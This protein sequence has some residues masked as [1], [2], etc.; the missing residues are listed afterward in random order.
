LTEGDT[1]EYSYD[2]LRDACIFLHSED[3]QIILGIPSRKEYEAWCVNLL[4]SFHEHYP[5]KT[6][7]LSFPNA[8]ETI[9]ETLADEF[10]ENEDS[11]L[12]IRIWVKLACLVPSVI[13]ARNAESV[14]DIITIIQEAVS[15]LSGGVMPWE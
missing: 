15:E 9:A 1:F 12:V 13:L 10:E 7:L 14:D 8:I 4:N 6:E 5:Q 2:S 11:D 3:D